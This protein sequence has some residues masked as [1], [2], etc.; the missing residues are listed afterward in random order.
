M[1]VVSPYTPRGYI[2]H[3]VYGFGSIVRFVEE[4]FGLKSLGTTD[5]TSNSLENMFDFSQ[6]PRPFEQIPSE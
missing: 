2:S 3:T 6:S 1:L 5:E 4:T